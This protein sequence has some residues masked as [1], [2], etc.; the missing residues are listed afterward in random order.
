[1]LSIW[2]SL[3]DLP[4]P[5]NGNPRRHNLPNVLTI[6]LKASFRGAESC[7]DFTDFARDRKALFREFLELPGGLTCHG[8]FSRLLRLPGPAAFTSCFARFL[9]GP[10][11]VGIVV[12]AINGKTM[13]FVRPRGGPLAFARRHRVRGGHADGDRPVRGRRQGKR[14]HDGANVARS[15][16]SDLRVGE[17]RRAALS[18]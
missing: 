13:P 18:D 14:D 5:R 1:M 8:T 3:A 9:D 11:E 12:I 17:G 10:G 6:A 4:D 15:H 16:R 2:S 7:V